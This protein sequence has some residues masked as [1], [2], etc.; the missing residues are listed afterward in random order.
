MRLVIKI[1]FG[2]D[3]MQRYSQARSII[4]DG[5]GMAEHR[6]KPAVGDSGTFRDVNGNRVGSWAVVDI[7]KQEEAVAELLWDYL[8]R[9]PE[10]RDRRATGWGTKTLVG[11]TACVNR[12]FGGG[13]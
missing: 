4:R 8:K 3:A 10:H 1:D 7:E 9:D 2:N 6:A 5:L 11:L 12:I 13:E